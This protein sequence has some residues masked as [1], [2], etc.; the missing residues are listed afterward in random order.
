MR[1]RT[2][3]N[4]DSGHHSSHGGSRN[5]GDDGVHIRN[6]NANDNYVNHTQRNNKTGIGSHTKHASTCKKKNDINQV[7]SSSNG[8]RYQDK[9]DDGSSDDEEFENMNVDREQQKLDM[10]EISQ[11]SQKCDD[12]KLGKC[13]TIAQT[14]S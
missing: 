3:R 4:D 11:K 12:E 8:Y 5:G 6:R 14:G 2:T 9:K 7:D 10:L 13:D 1:Q